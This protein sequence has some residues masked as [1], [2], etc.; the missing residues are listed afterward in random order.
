LDRI[1]APH[2]R[3][4][5][6][7]VVGKRKAKAMDARVD[8]CGGLEDNQGSREDV[9]AV[10]LEKCRERRNRCQVC[11]AW[12]SRKHLASWRI[13][14]ARTLLIS[15]LLLGAGLFP[16][17]VL[18]HLDPR[19]V[20]PVARFAPVTAPP[21]PC[22]VLVCEAVCAVLIVSSVPLY[23]ESSFSGVIVYITCT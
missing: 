12:R 5:P 22:G 8:K 1:V 13:L 4:S 21:V 7:L 11:C 20:V 6:T 16:G 14:L 18:R 17:I 2:I 9:V 10:T 19:M 3:S 23:D 15:S